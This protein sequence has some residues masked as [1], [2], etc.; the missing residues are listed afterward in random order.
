VGS[1]DVIS[2][3]RPAIYDGIWFTAVSSIPSEEN[4]AEGSS[5]L[6]STLVHPNPTTSHPYSLDEFNSASQGKGAAHDPFHDEREAWDLQYRLHK[7]SLDAFNHAFWTDV[8][9]TC[10]YR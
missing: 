3:L 8:R 9:T 6:P 4:T 5:A 10:L 1:P 2:N 7:Q